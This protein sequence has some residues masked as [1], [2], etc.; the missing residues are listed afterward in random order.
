MKLMLIS[1]VKAR[2]G[3][4]MIEGRVEETPVRWA[5]VQSSDRGVVVDPRRSAGEHANKKGDC[6]AHE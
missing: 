4:G 5:S 2:G 6:V 1:M 3:D